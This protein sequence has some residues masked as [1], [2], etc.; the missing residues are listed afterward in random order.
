MNFRVAEKHGNNQCIWR[1]GAMG[2][3]IL[4]LK[5]FCSKYGC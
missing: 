5:N 2:T 4:R 3:N 1:K